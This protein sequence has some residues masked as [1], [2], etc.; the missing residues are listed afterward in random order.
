VAFDG[1]ANITINAVDNTSGY[2]TAA[3]VTTAITGYGYQTAAQVTTA[4]TAYGY[5]T[6]AQ[7]TTAITGYGYQTA[8]QVSSAISAAA[9]SLPTASTT[10][11]GGVKV[12]GTSI[13]VTGGVISAVGSAPTTVA[14]VT[15]WTG[16][17]WDISGSVFGVPAASQ[18][19]VRFKA[20]R[21]FVIPANCAASIAS[22]AVAATASAVFN[23]QK[24]GATV[25]TITFGAG[26]TTGTFSNQAAITYAI[27]D[28]FR[29]VDPSTADATLA[30]IDFTIAAT[31]A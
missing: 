29:I 26:A 10:T 5:Q 11:L 24:N 19:D 16:T 2:Q 17:P 8:A 14:S 22:S 7:V 31:L 9:Y 27:G 18:V 25:A 28:Q 6:A 21:S 3:Q 12:D 30:D 15:T 13:T 23:I 4:V 1:S 20:A